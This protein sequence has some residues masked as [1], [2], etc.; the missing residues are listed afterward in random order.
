[1][2]SMLFEDTPDD[3]LLAWS[4]AFLASGNAVHTCLSASLF[5]I[6]S[7]RT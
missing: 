3:W 6:W 1:M 4:N 7:Q 2:R 5:V